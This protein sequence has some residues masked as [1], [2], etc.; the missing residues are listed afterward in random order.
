M[1][2]Y[3]ELREPLH[4]T[5]SNGTKQVLEDLIQAGIVRTYS[6]GIGYLA[7]FYQ[8][9]KSEQICTP[10]EQT[11]QKVNACSKCGLSFEDHG[12][13]PAGICPV[14]FLDEDSVKGLSPA[15]EEKWL[16]GGLTELPGTKLKY[17]M[18]ED[19]VT[20]EYDGTDCDTWTVDLIYG[21]LDTKGRERTS[22]VTALTEDLKYRQRKACA[23][24][25]FVRGVEQGAIQLP[26]YSCREEDPDADYKPML[27]GVV[28][29]RCNYDGANIEGTLG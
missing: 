5:I 29:T 6:K 17:Y 9:H 23:L 1:T 22:E 12:V 25:T 28:N 18:R 7:A 26:G 21:I 15:K 19:L 16:E 8:Q 20:L 10:G 4:T 2:R 3:T 27:Q 11:V 13:A 24:N 14:C